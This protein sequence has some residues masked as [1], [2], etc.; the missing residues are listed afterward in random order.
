MPTINILNTEERKQFDSPPKF[1]SFERKRFLRVN[2]QVQEVIDNLR[3]PT[4]RVAF[5]LILGYF[6]AS[7]KLFN[8]FYIADIEYGVTQLNLNLADIDMTSYSKQKFAFHKKIVLDFTGFQSFT[9]KV[10]QDM[11][12]K[13]RFALRS[14]T[15]H[16]QILGNLAD[17]LRKDG[18]EIPSYNTIAEAINSES[19]RYDLEIEQKLVACLTKADI[20]ELES[21]LTRTQEMGEQ[22]DQLLDSNQQLTP[23]DSQVVNN[24]QLSTSPNNTNNS[25]FTDTFRDT[26]PYLLTEL[27]KPYQSSQPSKIKKNLES[28][29]LL[30]KLFKKLE[31]AKVVVNFTDEGIKYYA[32]LT[33]KQRLFQ[34]IRKSSQARLIYFYCFV[35]NQYF[36]LND[37]LADTIILSA[38]SF[39]HQVKNAIDQ[40]YLESKTQKDSLVDK[41]AKSRTIQILNFNKVRAILK[42]PTL[43]DTQKVAKLKILIDQIDEVD[44][45]IPA[46]QSI[47]EVFKE[48]GDMQAKDDYY[49]I[50]KLSKSLILKVG[51]IVK[52]LEFSTNQQTSN[53][54][55]LQAI[56]HYRKTSG[57]IGVKPPTT[58]LKPSI[59]KKLKSGAKFKTS[60]YKVLLILQIAGNIKAGRL[61]LKYS[62]RYRSGEEYLLTESD[63]TQNQVT[64]LQLAN[65][66]NIEDF[67]TV[68]KLLQQKAQIAFDQ[69]NQGINNNLNPTI[70]FKENGEFSIKT[71]KIEESRTKL[72]DLLPKEQ[73][74]SLI[75]IMHTVAKNTSFCDLFD[76]IQGSRLGVD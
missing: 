6:K 18:I 25:N 72:S 61:N 74:I 73:Y 23:Q 51:N 58:F 65:L 21:L 49:F 4:N 47:E 11:R 9:P 38:N 3:T 26:T 39:T 57:D 22:Q 75:E 36:K 70:K 64:Y 10:E 19:N 14:Q 71:P 67:N 1:N 35:Y 69:T 55:L 63:F 8:Q 28:L 62:Y 40:H 31:P 42:D 37:T 59:V 54:E 32:S 16:R 45:V 56:D 33:I 20:I 48:L 34:I 53:L 27:K 68:D 5:L 13:I 41:I 12:D 66:Q 43:A 7:G 46:G 29:E 17:R 50:E 30:S 2:P 44:K 60:L 76:N 24:S 52:R 15:R